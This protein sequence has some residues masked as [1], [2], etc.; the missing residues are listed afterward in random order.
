M[1]CHSLHIKQGFR[2]AQTISFYDAVTQHSL[3]P[4]RQAK[5]DMEAASPERNLRRPR[6]E[7]VTSHHNLRG[8]P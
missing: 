4:E 3:Y 7:H 8:Q 2:L 6:D 5:D 1:L